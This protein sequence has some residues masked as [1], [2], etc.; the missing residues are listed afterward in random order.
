ME[1]QIC[2]VP[3][4]LNKPDI[5]ITKPFELNWK[6]IAYIGLGVG[7]AVLAFKTG[8]PIPYKTALS[9]ISVLGGLGGAAF[10]YEGNTIDELALNALTYQQR[11]V[12]YN[13]LE[14]R[15]EINVTISTRE[16][17]KTVD[18]KPTKLTVSTTKIQESFKGLIHQL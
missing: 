13:N 6:Q 4:N 7:G 1:K 3:R 15:G 16:E 2:M 8:L 10:Q 18:I 11:K 17:E 9:G 12:Y 5:I 14:K